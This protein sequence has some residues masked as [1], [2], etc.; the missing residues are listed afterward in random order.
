MSHFGAH[1]LCA[2]G[3]ALLGFTSMTSSLL[4]TAAAAETSKV[5]TLTDDSFSN[6]LDSKSFWLIDF[7]A[8]WCG[9]CK[10]LEVCSWKE[11]VSECRYYIEVPNALRQMLAFTIQPYLEC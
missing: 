11:K 7:Y 4:A 2:I 1:F 6:A 9:H 10:T 5:V 3:I 8:P